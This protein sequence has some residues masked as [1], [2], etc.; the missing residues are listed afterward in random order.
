MYCVSIINFIV[1]TN[2]SYI[3]NVFFTDSDKKISI[4]S[5]TIWYISIARTINDEIT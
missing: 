3:S 1:I 5:I 4:V 2:I